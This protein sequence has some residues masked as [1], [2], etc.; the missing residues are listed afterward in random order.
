MGGWWDRAIKASGAGAGGEQ[1]EY[2]QHAQGKCV[3][4]SAAEATA[5]RRVTSGHDGD[6]DYARDGEEQK[7][8]L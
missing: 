5:V 6:A 2:D 3:V 8:A 4:V 1:G 7:L